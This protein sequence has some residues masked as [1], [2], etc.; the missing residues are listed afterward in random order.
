MKLIALPLL[1][2]MP[3][4]AAFGQNLVANGSF[5]AQSVSLPPGFI[6]QNVTG[7]TP[8]GGGADVL[9]TGYSGGMASH[10]VNFVDIL[11]NSG[12]PGGPFPTGISQNIALTAGVSYE[13]RFDYNGDNNSPRSL[14]YAFGTLESGSLDVSMMN[15]FTAFGEVTPWGIF[16]TIV[17]P[18]ISGSY[19]LSFTTSSGQFCSPYVDNVSVT[20]V[21]EPSVLTLAAA[22]LG[23]CLMRRQG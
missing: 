22:G 23:L 12:S 8:V 10:G 3:L 19:L 1:L 2:G 16:S 13:L 18:V 4:A 6:V 5:E 14:D 20:A 9:V 21:P 15:A 17:T 7:W 11:G